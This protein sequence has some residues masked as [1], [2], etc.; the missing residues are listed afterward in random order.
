MNSAIVDKPTV[1]EIEQMYNANDIYKEDAQ[2][3]QYVSPEK[4]HARGRGVMIFSPSV[5]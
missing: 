5:Y 2:G 4:I 1:A 3:K